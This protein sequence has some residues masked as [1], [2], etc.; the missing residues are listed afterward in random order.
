MTIFYQIFY[1][2]PKAD[3]RYI[4]GFESAFM[5]REDLKILRYIQSNARIYKY[6][7]PWVKKM[8]PEDRLILRA[9]MD[10][11]PKISELEWNYTALNIWVGR[12]PT[13]MKK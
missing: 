8:K 9:D 1:K 10:H 7:G 12:K 4:L 3:W 5:P 13:E 11:Q 6:F 2:N